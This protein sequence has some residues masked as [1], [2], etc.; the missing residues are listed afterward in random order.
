[1]YLTD[2]RYD[3]CFIEVNDILKFKKD[4]SDNKDFF[5]N[6][7][8]IVLGGRGGATTYMDVWDLRA[9]SNLNANFQSF[10]QLKILGDAAQYYEN[11]MQSGTVF[12]SRP[13]R[14]QASVMF[15]R[16]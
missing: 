4:V 13:V 11:R 3:G 6:I 16:I 5:E 2:Q 12:T 9:Y 15:G 10:E 14:K 8:S 1:M 7:S